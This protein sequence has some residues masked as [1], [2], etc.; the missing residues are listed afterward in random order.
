ML[1]EIKSHHL[2][3]KLHHAYL[4]VA[5]PETV[6][7]EL[8]ELCADILG[9]SAV[10]GHPDY[11]SHACEFFRIEDALSLRQA[12]ATTGFGSRRIFVIEARSVG[13][14]ATDALLKTVEDAPEGKHFFLVT[15]GAD[16][17]LPTLLSRVYRI[18]AE[19]GR[20]Y[21]VEAKKF[22]ALSSKERIVAM[23]RYLPKKNAT[24]EDKKV[25]KRTLAAFVSA[26]TR[27]LH[28]EPLTLKRARALEAFEMVSGYLNDSGA[29]T[30]L[31]AE[32][33]ILA[34]HNGK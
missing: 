22:L 32:H 2:N 23:E 8:S 1:E 24:Q 3:N 14:E 13:H 28:Q 7:G 16:S 9:A 30:K 18:D 17:L 20:S 12:Q 31:L 29:A 6:R 25:S 21:E 10:I 26:L 4:I 15:P 27:E 33:A 19:G 11:W 34:V 5:E